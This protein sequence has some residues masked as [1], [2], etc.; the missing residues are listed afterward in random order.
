M[1]GVTR[2]SAREYTQVHAGEHRRG[3]SIMSAPVNSRR[4]TNREKL[5]HTETVSLMRLSKSPDPLVQISSYS[6][7]W[8]T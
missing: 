1:S 6:S 7:N 2:T 8:M 4:R 5:S 3:L